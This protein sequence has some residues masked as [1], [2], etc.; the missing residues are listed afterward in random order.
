M[1]PAVAQVDQDFTWSLATRPRGSAHVPNSDLPHPL[2]VDHR[3]DEHL[4]R[5]HK[6]NDPVAVSDQLADA[7]VI[8]L[9]HLP[10]RQREFAQGSCERHDSSDYRVGIGG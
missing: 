1:A 3:R 4:S 2:A 10:P 9:G 7:I 8:E 5:L 6:I